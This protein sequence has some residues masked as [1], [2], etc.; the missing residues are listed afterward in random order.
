ML[1]SGALLNGE[2][3]DQVLLSQSRWYLGVM[4][5]FVPLAIAFTPMLTLEG[6]GLHRGMIELQHPLLVAPL[7]IPVVLPLLQAALSIR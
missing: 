2:E 5:T 6:L 3:A 7:L 1:G 4:I